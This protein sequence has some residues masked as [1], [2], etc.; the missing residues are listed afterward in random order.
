M[1]K[2]TITKQESGQTILKYIKKLFNNATLGFIEKIFRKKKITING[3]KINKK[4]IIQENDNLIIF[5]NEKQIEKINK[6]LPVPD[7]VILPNIV[8]EDDNILIVNKP[9]KILV[10]EDA[11]KTAKTLINQVTSYVLKKNKEINFKPILCHRLD[12]NTSG[13]IVFA[14][15]IKSSQAMEDAFK[16]KKIKKCYIALVFGCLKDQFG[17]I[18]KPLKKKNNYVKIS[19]DG[20]KSLT[21][22]HVIKKF[23][24]FT[25][26]EV[27][28]ITGRTH[29]IRV[30]MSSIG[31][32]IVGDNKYGDFKK[33]HIFRQRFNYYSQFLHAYKIQFKNMND[34]LKYLSNKTFISELNNKEK[35]ILDSLK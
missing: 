7:N 22:F 33:N 26:I 31:F 24:D 10:H 4:Y 13:L 20:K 34:P 16:N 28:L 8:Y 15:S 18:K 21:K 2:I 27:F 25:L 35:I 12:Y 32:P 5:L 17:L 23:K 3:K 1:K 30:H 9:K 6:I 19:N 14:K 11:T 29:Q